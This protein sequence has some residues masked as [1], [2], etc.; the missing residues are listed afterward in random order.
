MRENV[1]RNPARVTEADYIA[2]IRV[3]EGAWVCEQDGQVIGFTIV[4]L[5]REN[6]W[7]LF[8]DPDHQGR[9]I[10]RMLHDMMLAW[11]FENGARRLQLYT[12]AGTRAEWFY[13][14]AGWSLV[15]VTADSDLEFEMTRSQW[16][17]LRHQG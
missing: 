4:E 13:T 14:R 17:Q 11:T 12:E 3:G 9:G 8:V 6:V 15:A 2:R 7:A 16:R 10:G 1:L 5:Q